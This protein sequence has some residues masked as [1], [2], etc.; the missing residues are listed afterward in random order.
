MKIWTCRHFPRY[1]YI[2]CILLISLITFIIL[3]YFKQQLIFDDEDTDQLKFCDKTIIR[4]Y[5]M[6]DKR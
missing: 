5:I 1:L 3:Q 2:G 6:H 4:K